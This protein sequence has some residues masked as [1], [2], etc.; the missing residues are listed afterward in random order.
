[1]LIINICIS[2]VI[3]IIIEAMVFAAPERDEWHVMSVCVCVCINATFIA[4]FMFLL[5]NLWRLSPTRTAP[6]FGF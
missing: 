3:H 6:H 4:I 1:M 2:S 5:E